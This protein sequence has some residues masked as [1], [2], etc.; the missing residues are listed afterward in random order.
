ML[1][2]A[3]LRLEKDGLIKRYRVLSPDRTTVREI[4]VV[5]DNSVWTE[6]LELRVVERTEP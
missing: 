3:L 6:T 2:S 4:Q 5:F 1:K